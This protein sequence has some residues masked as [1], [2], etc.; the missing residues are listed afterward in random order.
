MNKM[1]KKEENSTNPNKPICGIIMP[2]SSIDNCSE[3][4]WK[5]VKGIITDAIE[6]A[7]FEAKLVSEAND[8][9]IIQKRIVQNLYN[10][11][12]VVCDVSCKNP[13]VMFELGMRLAFDKPTIIVMDN[14]TK[15]SFDTAPIE[16]LGYPRDLSYYQIIEFK[17][18]LTKKIKG[19]VD[20]A[21][22]PG[23]TTFLK[24]FGEFHVASIENKEGS[25]N[26]VLI[27]RLD[28]ITK[29]ISDIQ[30]NQRGRIIGRR[31]ETETDTEEINKLTRKLI[32]QYCTD[33]NIS[34]RLLYNTNELDDA[35]RMLFNY[36]EENNRMR[37]LCASPVRIR[38][39]IS[40]N[41]YP[42]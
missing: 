33:N 34:E 22:A 4:H 21:Q 37:D 35:R 3:N 28:D 17:E 39:A 5:E 9:G 8:S 13:N 30:T 11:D 26:D 16:H 1:N 29:Q 38:R 20:A 32:Q 40:E 19:T 2:I 6:K 7:G 10:N 12:I 41:L 24:N 15:Y 27:S 18:T 23:Y 36:I 14:M 31:I 25:I 42:F